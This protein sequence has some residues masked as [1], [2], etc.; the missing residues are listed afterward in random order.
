ML[1]LLLASALA[2]SSTTTKTGGLKV[3]LGLL[4]VRVEFAGGEWSAW[5]DAGRVTAMSIDPRLMRPKRVLEPI[6]AARAGRS[7]WMIYDSGVDDAQAG[8]GIGV[9]LYLALA[10]AISIAGGVLISNNGVSP[11]L[12]SYAAARTWMRLLE[13]PGIAGLAVDDHLGE[14]MPG[15]DVIPDTPIFLAWVEGEPERDRARASLRARMARAIVRLLRR[16]E[17]YAWLD[18]EIEGGTFSAGGCW[19]LAATIASVLGP[20]A[21]LW[22]VDGER[23]GYPVGADI[24]PQHVFVRF[25]TGALD[26]DGETPFLGYD[27]VFEDREGL[28]YTALRPID[29][30][31]LRA[32]GI[33]PAPEL[34]RKLE[35][36][37]RTS[38]ARMK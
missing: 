21:E 4:P 24:P 3:R 28:A 13:V 31:S 37:L 7:L 11:A 38:L 6:E 15:E 18:A 12:T 5:C 27:Q 16:P 35:E 10:R 32:A 17:P 19:P 9:E 34:A 20:D 8:A 30:A 33:P 23:A 29:P 26:A 22:Q 25:G 1:L 14:E 2:A 36:A